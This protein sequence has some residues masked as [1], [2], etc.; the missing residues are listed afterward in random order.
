MHAAFTEANDETF[1]GL[2][3]SCNLRLGLEAMPEVVGSNSYIVGSQSSAAAGC[4]VYP[5]APGQAVH[6]FTTTASNS[7]N[8]FPNRQNHRQ[9][10]QQQ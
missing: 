5:A 2:Q 10:Q 4:N 1:A 9:Q 8:T 7:G 3:L 6:S